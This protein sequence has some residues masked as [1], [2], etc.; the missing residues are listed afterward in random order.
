MHIETWKYKCWLLLWSGLYTTVA[1]VFYANEAF[2]LRYSIC[3]YSLTFE[4]DVWQNCTITFPV[5]GWAEILNGGS[6]IFLSPSIQY[7]DRT[8][9]RRSLMGKHTKF[10]WVYR[11]CHDDLWANYMCTYTLSVKLGMHDLLVTTSPILSYIW[12]TFSNFQGLQP[13]T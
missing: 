8:M 9:L 11:R 6:L 2:R 13:Q 4:N 1:L 12:P 7:K 3:C 10:L 5:F